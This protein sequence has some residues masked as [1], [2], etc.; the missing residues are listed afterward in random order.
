MVIII[1]TE[2]EEDQ[3][4][5]DIINIIDRDQVVHCYLYSRICKYKCKNINKTD[6]N[7]GHLSDE[8]DYN[9]QRGYL[10]HDDGN[11]RWDN[12]DEVNLNL[13]HD[14]NIMDGM[15]RIIIL[16]KE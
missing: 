14:S 7:S 16:K 15:V 13:R 2:K 9:R 1:D 12:K 6:Y 5:I 11:S 4:N 8:E 3:E 10:N